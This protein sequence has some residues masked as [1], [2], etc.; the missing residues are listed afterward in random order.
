MAEVTFD[1]GAFHLDAAIIGEGLNLEPAEVPLLM[2][3]GKITS[4]CERGEEEDA[5]RHRL[6]LFYGNRRLRL[7]VDKDGTVIKR[8]IV[9][10]G[11]QPLPD[12]M[13]KPGS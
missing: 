3:E 13:R 11:E 2:R 10:F 4:L 8:S 6:T 5:G 12:G 7:I 9:D 1:D